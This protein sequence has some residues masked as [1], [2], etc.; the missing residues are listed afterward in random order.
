MDGRP[1]NNLRYRPSALDQQF[2]GCGASCRAQAQCCHA[3]AHHGSN[4]QDNSTSTMGAVQRE[5][6]T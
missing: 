3:R 6:A 1:A 4:V 5:R 2:A